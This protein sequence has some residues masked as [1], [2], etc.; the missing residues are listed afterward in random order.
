MHRSGVVLTAMVLLAGCGGTT[1]TIVR[2]SIDEGTQRANW[3]KLR[4]PI[5]ELAGEVANGVIAAG[6]SAELAPGLDA[7]VDRFVRTVLRAASQGLD[8]DVTPALARTLRATIDEAIAAILSDTTAHRASDIIDAVTAA[9]MAGLARG[10][11]DQ[12]GPAIASA[13]DANL[14]PAMQRVIEHNLGPAIARTLEHD[15]GPAFARTLDTTIPALARAAQ[16]TAAAAGEGFVEGVNRSAGPLVDHQLGRLQQA[17][18]RAE[19]DAHSL[20][21]F[22]PVAILA[23]VSGALSVLLWWRHRVATTGRDA[24]HLVASEIGRMSAEPTIHELAR[25]IKTAGEGRKAGA[26]LADHLRAHPSI[27]V[28]V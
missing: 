2:D 4:A 26:F 24:L 16:A 11:R 19:Q 5:R 18:D 21:R 7:A 22:L 9:A 15:L 8:A 17:L 12:I 13:L 20:L 28:K 25:R 1:R 27:K 14:G 6:T 23:I 3:D 10:L